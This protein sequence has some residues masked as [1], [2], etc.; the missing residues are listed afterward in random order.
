MFGMIS[1]KNFDKSAYSLQCSKFAS[2]EENVTC[3]KYYQALDAEICVGIPIKELQYTQILHI[4]CPIEWSITITNCAILLTL[5]EGLH[6][7]KS[8]MQK[9]NM[10]EIMHSDCDA[11]RP[12][13]YKGDFYI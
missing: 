5:C 12:L 10:R 8:M 3:I 2:S 9:G 7:S 13:Q 4:I 1:K 6:I 11:Y